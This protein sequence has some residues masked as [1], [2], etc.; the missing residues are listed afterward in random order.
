VSKGSLNRETDRLFSFT[1]AQATDID[2]FSITEVSKNVSNT[3]LRM[4]LRGSNDDGE[5][6]R[7]VGQTAK[8]RVVSSGVRFLDSDLS[9]AVGGS[10]TYDFGPPWPLFA[11]SYMY[12]ILLAI[13]CFCAGLLGSLRSI[14]TGKYVFLVTGG[15]CSLNAMIAG[16]GYVLLGLSRDSFTPFLY[17]VIFLLATIILWKFSKY[18][19]HAV[20]MLAMVSVVGRYIQDCSIYDDCSFLSDSPPI[21]PILLAAIGTLILLIRSLLLVHLIRSI[22]SDQAG[23]DIRWW[24]TMQNPVERT[25]LE[26]L[27]SAIMR[28]TTTS[29]P[30]IARQL[31]RRR[32]GET[33]I[34]RESW[35]SALP[36]ESNCL[37]SQGHC[38]EKGRHGGRNP[39]RA[40]ED[41]ALDSGNS[42]VAG[43]LD[44][45]RPVDSLDQLYAQALSVA[46][47]LEHRAAAWAETAHG[48]MGSPGHGPEVQVPAHAPH[49][50]TA[51]SLEHL[52]PPAGCELV[53][54][55]VLKS[56]SRAA[57]KA[58][59]CYKG[60]V[61][62]LLD[63]AR[64][65]L[66]FES[67]ADLLACV[68]LVC[69]Q[70]PAVRVV[71]VKNWLHETHDSDR[72]AGFRVRITPS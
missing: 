8:F 34:K 50:S 54:R 18:F 28:I 32:I 26:H 60:D 49:L 47:L 29:E 61:S 10:V 24:E 52:L 72:T 46:S 43:Q 9:E 20:V 1:S 35:V 48:C 40:G 22:S 23:F 36:P 58:A 41:A 65:R 38:V 71:R 31:N 25:I 70:D 21:W 16:V 66:Y 55:G 56:P 3:G 45:G 14:C 4:L 39:L 5:T 59:S 68:E 13:G 7:T 69:G 53:R 27:H 6:W 30:G 17:S 2:G 15:L 33:S 64:A 62:R 11:H 12:R 57:E 67:A 37:S 19:F 63:I 42:T 44:A 51:V